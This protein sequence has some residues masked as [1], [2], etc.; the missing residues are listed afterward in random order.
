MDVS[1]RLSLVPLY[2]TGAKIGLKDFQVKPLTYLNVS[3]FLQVFLLEVFSV[4]SELYS[5][6]FTFCYAKSKSVIIFSGKEEETLIK[7][8]DKS[9]ELFSILN[10]LEKNQ[11]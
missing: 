10:C 5:E 3:K 7:D 11:I 8:N 1:Y 2:R 9:N 6:L 4:S